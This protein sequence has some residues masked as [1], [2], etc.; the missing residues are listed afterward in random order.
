MIA[1]EATGRAQIGKWYATTSLR[2]VEF[3]RLLNGFKGDVCGGV[4]GEFT[5][6]AGGTENA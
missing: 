2:P 1:Q 6:F 3:E 4:G 5:G